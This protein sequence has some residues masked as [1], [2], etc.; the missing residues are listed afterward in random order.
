[1]GSA[2]YAFAIVLE[3]V[4]RLYQKL[5]AFQAEVF[6]IILYFRFEYYLF[7]WQLSVNVV[8]TRKFVVYKSIILISSDLNCLQKLCKIKLTGFFPRELFYF[9]GLF[10]T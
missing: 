2:C 7:L 8:S 5:E 1:M 10:V 4:R 6:V 9:F 3:I